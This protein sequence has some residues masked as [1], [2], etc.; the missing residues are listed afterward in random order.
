MLERAAGDDAH[1][2]GD[3]HLMAGRRAARQ[4]GRSRVIIFRVGSR[5]RPAELAALRPSVDGEKQQDAGVGLIH[6]RTNVLPSQCIHGIDGTARPDRLRPGLEV[7]ALEVAALA[8][9][10][11]W[12]VARVRQSCLQQQS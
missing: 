4:A 10:R 12:R 8:D 2:D 3:A 7:V 9:G 6:E 5:V 11:L 1:S